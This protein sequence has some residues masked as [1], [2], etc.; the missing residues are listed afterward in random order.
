MITVIK[1]NNVE[2]YQLLF[3]EASDILSG[4]ERVYTY[5]VNK[6]YYY[7]TQDKTYEP[8]T[9]EGKDETEKIL[10]F[11][12]KLTDH[13]IYTPI[14]NEDGTHKKNDQFISQLGITTLEEYYNWLPELK[15]DKEGNPTKYTILPLLNNAD[16]KIS[17]G[18]E[19]FLIDANSRAIQIPA[20]FKKNGIAVQGDDLAEVVY[21]EVDRYFDA[22]DLN[23]CQIFIQWE[24]PKSGNNAAI[25]SISDNY[26]RDI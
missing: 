7:K 19:P 3:E 12:N 9:L 21:F 25:K 10:D 15:A 11:A 1:P 2:A 24:T 23:N 13:K 22:V 14:L 20:E 16:K 8:I 18:E 17:G 4:Y 5:D 26:L 6:D